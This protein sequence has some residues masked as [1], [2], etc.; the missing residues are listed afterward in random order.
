MAA[1]I[2]FAGWSEFSGRLI[3]IV[4][5][6]EEYTPGWIQERTLFLKVKNYCPA[7]RHSVYLTEQ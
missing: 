6:G 7:R 4:L 3:G 1:D 2:V 5:S